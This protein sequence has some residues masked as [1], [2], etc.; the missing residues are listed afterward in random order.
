MLVFHLLKLRKK[1]QINSC[2][3]LI[4][5]Q[6]GAVL[7]LVSTGTTQFLQ[8]RELPLGQ[9]ISFDGVRHPENNPDVL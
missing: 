4:T 7:Y 3:E 1:F 8:Y 5:D 9:I 2:A 6:D